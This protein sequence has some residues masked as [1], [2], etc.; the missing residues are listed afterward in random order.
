MTAL[1]FPKDSSTVIYMTRPVTVDLSH[2]S[3]LAHVTGGLIRSR[4]KAIKLSRRK[5]DPLPIHRMANGQRGCYFINLDE[6]DAWSKRQ[7][8]I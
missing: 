6:F 2:K 3:L 5:I 4:D 7:E 8:L 1:D